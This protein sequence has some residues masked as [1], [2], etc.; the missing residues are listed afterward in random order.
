M[1]GQGGL[2]HSVLKPKEI[3]MFFLMYKVRKKVFL[4]NSGRYFAA[5]KAKIVL[6]GCPC[7]LKKRYNILKICRP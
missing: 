7:M 4:R 6:S 5:L 3:N 2:F 1:F